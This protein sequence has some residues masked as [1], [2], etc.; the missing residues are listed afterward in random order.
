MKVPSLIRIAVVV[1]AVVQKPLLA[2]PVAAGPKDP[3]SF[4]VTPIRQG[5]CTIG[6]SFGNPRNGL[7]PSDLL[8]LD[9]NQSVSWRPTADQ[10]LWCDAVGGSTACRLAA[11]RAAEM[12]TTMTNT[13]DGLWTADSTLVGDYAMPNKLL[14]DTLLRRNTP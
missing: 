3:D 11:I 4:Q 2:T 12:R 13:R 6:A 7:C 5:D 8:E 9:T 1:L 14:R 10:S